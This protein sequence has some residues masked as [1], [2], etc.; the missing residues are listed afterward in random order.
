M[1]TH[2]IAAANPHQRL[3]IAAALVNGYPTPN[4]L[5]CQHREPTAA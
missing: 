1:N 4:Q 3:L 2:T 5:L